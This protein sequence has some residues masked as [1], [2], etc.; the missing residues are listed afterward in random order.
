MVNSTFDPDEVASPNL[1]R[2]VL[3]QASSPQTDWYHGGMFHG[4]GTL[5]MR[6]SYD[7]ALVSAV[8]NLR[9]FS[10][11]HHGSVC[12]RW[13]DEGPIFWIVQLAEVVAG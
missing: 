12:F 9:T 5:R 8:R 11:A 7:E 1:A 4:P 2:I 6:C 13:P 3:E 10:A